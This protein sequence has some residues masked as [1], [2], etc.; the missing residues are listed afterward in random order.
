MI[1][2]P[3]QLGPLPMRVA[4]RLAE[5]AVRRRAGQEFLASVVRDASGALTLVDATLLNFGAVEVEGVGFK[6]GYKYS[7]P[8]GLWAPLLAAQ[9]GEHDD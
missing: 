7:L 3:D 4:E 1:Q 8:L 9:P 5:R 2:V 6:L